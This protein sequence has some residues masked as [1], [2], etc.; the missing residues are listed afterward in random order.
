MRFLGE[1]GTLQYQHVRRKCSTKYSE[2]GDNKLQ[3][4]IGTQVTD[5]L[6]S[7]PYGM[8]IYSTC[9]SYKEAKYSVCALVG[10]AV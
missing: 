6:H 9:Y 4:N 8:R 1:C 7:L 2:K 10:Q 5:H 3:R